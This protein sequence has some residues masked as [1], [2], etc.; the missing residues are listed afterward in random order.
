MI[1]NLK[2]GY[3]DTGFLQISEEE[4]STAIK[5]AIDSGVKNIATWCFE[6]GACMTYIS[7]ERPE[8]VWDTISKEYR[9]LQQ[10]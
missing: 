9:N 1:R 8:I 3:R 6:G 7:S 2:Y 4:I 5:A 10:K